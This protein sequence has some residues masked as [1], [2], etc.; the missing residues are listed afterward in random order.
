MSDDGIAAARRRIDADDRITE[1]TVHLCWNDY[2]IRGAVQA[3]RNANLSEMADDVEAHLPKPP[4]LVEQTAAEFGR[5]HG[6]LYC[7][8]GPLAEYGNR[9]LM[10]LRDKAKREAAD[11]RTGNGRA[12]ATTI[13]DW[14]DDH[15]QD[16]AS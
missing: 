9:L 10:E 6:S 7:A 13:A 1:P 8:S 2:A 4:T 16:G 15:I 11:C 5:T 3:L 14:L 12:E